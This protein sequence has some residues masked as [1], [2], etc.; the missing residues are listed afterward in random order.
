[1]TCKYVCKKCHHWGEHTYNKGTEDEVTKTG[2]DVIDYGNL[3]KG[4]LNSY[5]IYGNDYGTMHCRDF[6]EVG[7]AVEA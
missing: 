6:R 4:G 2:C 3:Q 5:P 7:R 1:M